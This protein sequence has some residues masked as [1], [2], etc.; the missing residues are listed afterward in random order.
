M[1]ATCLAK[2]DRRSGS[3]I[4][5]ARA[6]AVALVLALCG[7]GQAWIAA[8]SWAGPLPDRA[9]WAIT[10]AMNEPRVFHSATRLADGRVLLAGGSG[11]FGETTGAEIYD[12][13]GGTS[14]PT[15]PMTTARAQHTA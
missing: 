5:L 12:Q 9:G 11:V 7:L 4:S 14:K 3:E 1:T 2:R 10:A 6:A 8:S 13:A 15:Q